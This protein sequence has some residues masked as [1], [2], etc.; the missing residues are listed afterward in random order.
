MGI[1]TGIS[2][3]LGFVRDCLLAAAYGTGLPAQAFVIAFRIPNLL[4]DLV[5]EGAANAAFVPVMSRIRAT[6]GESSW[7]VL[8]QAVW[9]RLSMG[10]LFFCAG[11]VLLAP[12]LVRGIAPGFSSDPALF[13]LT[14]RLTR[15][16]FPFIGLVSIAAL[17]MG[18]LNSIHRFAAAS[19]APVLL[20][21]GIIGGLLL[22][23]TDALGPAWGVVLGGILGLLI[24]VPSVRKEGVKLGF[25]VKSHPGV[26]QI[27]QLLVPRMVGT[28]VYQIGA[29]VDTIF[30]SFPRLVGTGG[31]VSLYFAFRFLHLPL[32]LFGISMA[33]AA[34]PTMA[35]QA[36]FEDLTA[37]KKTCAEALR[38]SLLIAIPATLGLLFMGYPIVQS[39]LERGAF[40]SEATK[41]TV[42]VLRWYAAG[43][44]FMC[45]AKVLANTLYAMHDTWTPVR[46]AAMAL[47]ANVVLNFAL[48][49]PFGLS[50]LALATS[51]S[52]ALNGFQLYRAV[53]QRVGP[54]E[55]GFT[56]WSMKVLVASLGM[57]ILTARLWVLLTRMTAPSLPPLGGLH[58]VGL[59]LLAVG[60]GVVSFL[61]LAFLLRVEEIH[62]LAQWLLNSFPWV[63]RRS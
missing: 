15:I 60:F 49:F 48:V 30:A 44:V 59:L 58:S 46:C 45:M 55:G 13:A 26:R 14:V 12:W 42:S 40:T 9:V 33:Q 1:F 51:L 39:L 27:A 62:R 47:G 32:A 61:A 23:E 25:Q 29:V 4:R 22:W 19:F 24:Q 38:S 31:V 36:A 17:F 50:G 52:S 53:R 37:V 63:L 41:T 2:R 18:I 35:T 28:G 57:G 6:Q 54:F 56:R 3:I 16:I 8:V 5:G 10:S 20:N 34:L 7:G 11:G 43:L 21:L